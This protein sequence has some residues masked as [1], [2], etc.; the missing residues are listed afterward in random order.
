MLDPALA[1]SIGI[2]ASCAIF[3]MMI[4]SMATVMKLIRRYLDYVQQNAANKK[5]RE[6]LRRI[7][8]RQLLAKISN[9]LS[10]LFESPP[11]KPEHDFSLWQDPVEFNVAL[12]HHCYAVGRHKRTRLFVSDYPDGSSRG[13]LKRGSER[14]DLH[15]VTSSN[16]QGHDELKSLALKS[17]A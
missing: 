16:R 8:R 12:A 10:K 6:R 11:Q 14:T 9:A 13:Y 15:L 5:A 2:I 17:V 3:M 4:F 1:I 7:R